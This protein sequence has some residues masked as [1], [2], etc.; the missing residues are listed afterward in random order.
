MN[1]YTWLPE[2]SERL[3]SFRE[4]FAKEVREK[5][6]V[7]S[8][9]DSEHESI[10]DMESLATTSASKTAEEI[11]SEPL[12]SAVTTKACSKYLP[13]YPDIQSLSEYD[14]QRDDVR[15]QC[16]QKVWEDNHMF[17]FPST[18]EKNMWL[19]SFK[20]LRYSVSTDTV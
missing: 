6:A 10:E 16:L 8:M 1:Y 4:F 5:E 12:T 17:K 9:L 20:W 2:K 11:V 14:L 18:Y 7:A 13:S 3:S 19:A 15:L